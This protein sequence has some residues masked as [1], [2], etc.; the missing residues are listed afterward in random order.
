MAVSVILVAPVWEL[1]EVDTVL[2]HF[3][4]ALHEVTTCL[5]IGAADFISR[6]LILSRAHGNI[7]RSQLQL[8][9]LTEEL[10]AILALEWLVWEIATHGAVDLLRHFPLQ[11]V[12]DF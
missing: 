2:Q 6:S 1:A 3:V 9:V 10:V 7:T 12:L 8:A 11:L 5:T 4:D